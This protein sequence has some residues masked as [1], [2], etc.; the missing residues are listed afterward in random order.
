MSTPAP[1][2]PNGPRLCLGGLAGRGLAA[3][4][5]T[6]G[7]RIS[8]ARSLSLLRHLALCLPRSILCF[9]A[10]KRTCLLPCGHRTSYNAHV[11]CWFVRLSRPAD[12]CRFPHFACVL[13][14]PALPEH[15]P[16]VPLIPGR[17]LSV[18]APQH[19]RKFPMPLAPSVC[20]RARLL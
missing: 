15:K 18:A 10:C 19:Q 14:F 2:H 12:F 8:D 7:S 16:S 3:A 11:R 1:L 4:A 6:P 20:I 9:D 13:P 17:W 5:L